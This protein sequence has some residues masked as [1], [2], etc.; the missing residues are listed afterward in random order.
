MKRLDT[1]KR[2]AKYVTA[3]LT[4][5]SWQRI[6]SWLTKFHSFLV[7]H[8]L[9]AVTGPPTPAMMRDDSL[10]LEFLAMIADEQKGRTRVNAAARAIEFVRKVMGI[11]PLSDD[12]RTALLKRGVL[13]YNP[14]KP[15]GA[16]PFPAIA[17]IAI[18]Q[19]WGHSKSWWQRAVALAIYLAFVALLRGAELLAIPRRGLTWVS[20][21]GETTNPSH[22]P[23][24]H[25]GVALLLPRRKTKQTEWSWTTVRA[26]KVTRLLSR[27]ARWLR[28]QKARPRYLFPSRTAR[29]RG[30]KRRW[31][32]NKG[33]RMSTA[34]L[35]NLTRRALREVCG[36]SATQ[37]RRFTVH[38]LRVGGINYYRSL[39]VST[40][41]RAQLADHMSLASSLRYLR[42]RPAD[43]IDILSSIVGGSDGRRP[44]P[45]YLRHSRGRK[46]R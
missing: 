17:V 9:D 13:R 38:S 16:V 10:S 35:L 26:G 5:G 14:A 43:Q 2:V 37:A 15:K 23:A 29:F 33:R 39:G 6:H 36:L 24:N 42:L 20:P 27:H 30:G 45:E 46:P 19:A 28:S 21:A 1:S 34:T 4:A 12:P 44:R 22:I 25:T 31:F 11:R 7:V 40:E 8:A 41:L 3:G 18:A 32:P